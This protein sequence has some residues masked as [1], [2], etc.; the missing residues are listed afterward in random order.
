MSKAT[1]GIVACALMLTVC[2]IFW[3]A[4]GLTDW[5]QNEGIRCEIGYD[6]VT[7]LCLD[8]VPSKRRAWDI[9]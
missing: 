8:R 6:P 3:L 7:H 9:L 2:V 4:R 5:G 1:D